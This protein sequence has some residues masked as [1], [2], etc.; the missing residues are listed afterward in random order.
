MALVIIIAGIM[1][2]KEEQ[3]NSSNSSSSNYYPYEFKN[4]ELK[5]GNSTVYIYGQARSE[6]CHWN[7]RDALAMQ[8]FQL[9]NQYTII[10]DSAIYSEKCANETL[11]MGSLVIHV[12][13]LLT[14]K[15]LTEVFS[16]NNILDTNLPLGMYFKALL[17]NIT[18]VTIS[19]GNPGSYS[20]LRID[21]STYG[22]TETLNFGSADIYALS[23]AGTGASVY[24]YNMRGINS[25]TSL[26]FDNSQYGGTCLDLQFSGITIP[27]YSGLTIGRIV[28]SY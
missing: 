7:N 10:N 12:L 15:N 25:A 23:F 14:P 2:N 22:F 3:T 4:G 9:S 28:V 24:W 19:E 16:I 20:N 5:S 11:D 13:Y 18:N 21:P 8:F 1:I 6:L 27:P 26:T 17:N